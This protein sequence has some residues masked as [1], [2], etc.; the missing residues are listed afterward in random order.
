MEHDNQCKDYNTIRIDQLDSLQKET[1]EL[2][3]KKNT[4]YN[5]KLTTH[6]GLLNIIN[7]LESNTFNEDKKMREMLIDLLNSV[8]MRIILLDN[9]STIE[10]NVDSILFNKWTIKGLSGNIYT[11]EN[12]R[13]PDGRVLRSC[14]CNSYKYSSNEYKYCKHTENNN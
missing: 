12:I 3:I 5:N 9:K 13:Y 8:T 2:F 11:R 4:S 10:N 7:Q 6:E 1:K 14:T